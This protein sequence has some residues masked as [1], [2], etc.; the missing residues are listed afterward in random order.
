[1]FPG[2]ARARPTVKGVES[3]LPECPLTRHPAVIGDDVLIGPHAHINGARIGDGCF[4]ATGIAL[5]PGC[6]AGAGSEVRIHGVVRPPLALF[7]HRSRSMLN[8]LP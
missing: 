7:W 1:M 6:V 8:V 2:V 5:F 4:L 3:C